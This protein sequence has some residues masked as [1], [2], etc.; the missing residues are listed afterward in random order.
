M[1]ILLRDLQTMQSKVMSFRYLNRKFFKDI[2]IF[3]LCEVSSF[4][5][6]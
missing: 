4:R 5:L 1:V 6:F 3:P 2:K